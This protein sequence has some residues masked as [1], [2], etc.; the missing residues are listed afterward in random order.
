M[1]RILHAGFDGLQKALAKFRTRFPEQTH[2]LS[3][4][5]GS[6]TSSTKEVKIQKPE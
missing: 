4:D 6:K 3:V 1:S 2:V 5:N